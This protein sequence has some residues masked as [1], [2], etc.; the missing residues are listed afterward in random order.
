MDWAPLQWKLP[1][2]LCIIRCCCVSK[3]ISIRC[4]VRQWAHSKAVDALRCLASA[5]GLQ[6]KQWDNKFSRKFVIQ[7]WHCVPRKES[8]FQKSRSPF[9]DFQIS[10]K[11]R[12]SPGDFPTCDHLLV[13]RFAFAWFLLQKYV[14]VF[15]F[16][17]VVFTKGTLST[18]FVGAIETKRWKR[19]K[20]FA[21]LVYM[22]ELHVQ[23]T[24]SVSLSSP[25]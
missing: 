17:K 6:S 12:Q 16:V 14:S 2:G 4:C 18:L 21:K 3:L 7:I 25:E 20:E 19:Q 11:V 8:E 5:N 15:R 10:G 9:R 13:C 24:F 23:A 22:S 1:I